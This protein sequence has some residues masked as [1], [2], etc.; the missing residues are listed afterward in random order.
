MVMMAGEDTS[1]AT[2]RLWV[3]W[4]IIF[5]AVGLAFV[6]TVVTLNN[7]VY[8]ASGFV[9]SYLSSLIR[10]DIDAALRMPGMRAPNDAADTL[11]TPNALPDLYDF[12]LVSD[13]DQGDGLHH[14][15]Y[16]AFFTGG[17]TAESTFL[18]QHTGARLGLF[19]A[20]SFAQSPLRVLQVTP[21]NDPQ[22]DVNGVTIDG[23]DGANLPYRYQVL[24]P[25]TFTLG[26]ESKYL[27]AAD[28]TVI[29]DGIADVVSTRVDIEASPAFVEQVAA[30]L[31]A[32]LDECATQQVLQPTGCPFGQTMR[33][34]IEGLPQWSITAYPEITIVPGSEPGTWLVPPTAATAH[35]HVDVRSLFDGTVSTFDEDVPF[36][37]QYT[38]TFPGDGS[39]LIT[40]V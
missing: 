22:F 24:T 33:N 28:K 26:H 7:T 8:S 20:W 9:S 36:N 14:V 5:G 10:H 1:G 37:V 2:H 6:G 4:A 13:K 29:V 3:K 32:Y 23:A 15:T 39:L 21:V 31:S 17:V 19:S 12:R 18:V 25:G 34:R 16:A 27:V 35:L 40:P 11:L 38:I 30:E